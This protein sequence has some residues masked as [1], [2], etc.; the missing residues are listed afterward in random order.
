MVVRSTPSSSAH[1]S[2]GAVIGRDFSHALLALVA[3]L[4]VGYLAAYSVTGLNLDLER[5]D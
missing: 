4:F 2:S 3:F 1:F 5:D